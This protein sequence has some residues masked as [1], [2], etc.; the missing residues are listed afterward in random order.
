MDDITSYQVEDP[1]PVTTL[2]L[3]DLSTKCPQNNTKTSLQAHQTTIQELTA[4]ED[5]GSLKEKEK[6]KLPGNLKQSHILLVLH[7]YMELLYYKHYS[8]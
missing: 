6:V 5:I 2:P 3:P 1:N 4:L 7:F 8:S